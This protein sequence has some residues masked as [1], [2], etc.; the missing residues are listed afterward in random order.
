MDRIDQF[1]KR[2][3]R[4]GVPDVVVW[5][6]DGSVDGRVGY[7]RALAGR[8]GAAGWDV[9]T[10]PL[11]RRPPTEHELAAPAHVLSGGN[12]GV[13][14]DVAWLD[15]ARRCLATVLDRALAG[16][17]SV[18]GICFGSQLIARVLAGPAAVG[19]HPEGMQAGL[20][21][22]GVPDG[23]TAHVV[24]SFH[25]HRIDR[26]VVERAGIRVTLTSDRTSV[27]AFSAGAGVH[28]VQFHPEL[29]PKALLRT[30]CRYRHV[31]ERH[32]TTLTR[33]S[34]SVHE[35]RRAW[36]DEVW[37]RYVHG[38]VAR[39]AGMPVGPVPAAA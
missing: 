35:H 22:V 9:V 19:P 20:V 23:P 39:T 12:T 29:A 32:G 16:A 21:R 15:D 38:A 30:L 26:S 3:G 6:A 1:D 11:T 36:R 31:L 33:S 8:L 5:E 17:T 13:N 34:A 2:R 18:T 25:Y 37:H 24:S 7:G 4:E 14:D 28:G 10:V 27:Q